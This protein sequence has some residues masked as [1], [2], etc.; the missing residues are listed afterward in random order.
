MK[1]KLTYAEWEQAYTDLRA[2]HVREAT[3]KLEHDYPKYEAK[4]R[5][6]EKPGQLQQGSQVFLITR[7]HSRTGMSRSVSLFTFMPVA[8]NGEQNSLRSLSLTHLVGRL[9]GYSVHTVNGHDV[10]R[11]DD[12]PQEFI[13]HLSQALFGKDQASALICEQL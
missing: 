10:I 3:A 12:Y 2:R 6:L 9:L 13:C 1:P 11:T 8:G 4:F 5:L 7:K